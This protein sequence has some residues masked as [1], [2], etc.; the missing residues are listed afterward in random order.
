[1][2]QSIGNVEYYRPGGVDSRQVQGT[3]GPRIRVST[4]ELD[5]TDR[6]L[7]SLLQE[8]ARYTATELAAELGVSDNTVH[9]RMERLEDAGVVTGYTATVDN[10]R[11]GFSLYFSFVCTA[12]ISERSEVAEEIM[13][14]PQVTEVTEL[15]TGHRNLLVNVYAATDEEVTAIARRLDELDLEINDENLVRAEHSKP[16]DYEAVELTAE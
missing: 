10:E 7:L 11:V 13:R 16:I 14:V 4:Y 12:R 15:M 3:R 6:K 9:N 8:N 1:M 2:R 5:A